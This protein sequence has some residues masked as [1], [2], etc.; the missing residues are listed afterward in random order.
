M[1]NVYIQNPWTQLVIDIKPKSNEIKPTAGSPLFV[2]TKGATNSAGDNFQLWTIVPFGLEAKGEVGWQL[3]QNANTRDIIKDPKLNSPFCID[4]SLHYKDS[5]TKTPPKGTPLD[6]FPEK[7]PDDDTG[8]DWGVTSNA[9]QLW[10]FYKDPASGHYFISNVL[11]GHVIDIMEGGL[12]PNQ[13]PGVGAGLDAYTRKSS[14]NQNQL[15]QFVDTAGALVT[16]PASPTISRGPGPGGNP[17][18]R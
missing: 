10:G 11:N 12:A 13:P 8:P 14:G 7:G 2:N 9:N 15:W 6:A 18:Q 5:S 3:I 16:P 1:P 4:I 17:V